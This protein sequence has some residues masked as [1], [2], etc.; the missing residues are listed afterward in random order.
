MGVRTGTPPSGRG[1][2]R[3]GASRR[4]PARGEPSRRPRGRRPSRRV[5]ARRRAVA[6]GLAL[7]AIVGLVLVVSWLGGGGGGS[8]SPAAARA[9]HH[10]RAA[11]PE[12]SPLKR[13]P[14]GPPSDERR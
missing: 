2:N 4:P 14:P 1:P 7:I 5:I 13:V 11:A 3:G 12:I 10:P 8:P 6:A 9:T